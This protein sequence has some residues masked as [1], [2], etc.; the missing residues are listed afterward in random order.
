[1]SVGEIQTVSEQRSAA[2]ETTFSESLWES[3]M[4]Y[5]R[6]VRVGNHVYIA[7]TVASDGEGRAQG[8]DAYA[9]TDFIIRKIQRALKELGADLHDVVSTVTHLSDFSHFDDYALAHKEHLGE[10]LPVNTTVQAQLVRPHFLVEVTATAI[11][12]D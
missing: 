7:G 1:M 10:V 9:Q 5:A 6:G 3:Q 4:G 12:A 2:R 11:V 8:E